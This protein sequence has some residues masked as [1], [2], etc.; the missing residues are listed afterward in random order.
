MV[1]R[2]RKN[3]SCKRIRGSGSPVIGEGDH[4]R[5][6]YEEATSVVKSKK[7]RKAS[8]RKRNL[9]K[10]QNTV[11]QVEDYYEELANNLAYK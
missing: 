8:R 11:K 9:A 4:E 2:T 3:R 10:K 1:H 6:G 5:L 7:S